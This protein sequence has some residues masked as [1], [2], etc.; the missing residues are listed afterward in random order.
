MHNLSRGGDEED[1]ALGS[2]TGSAAWCGE[3][4]PLDEEPVMFEFQLDIDEGELHAVCSNIKNAVPVI[5][6]DEESQLRPFSPSFELQEGDISEWQE[7]QSSDDQ[8]FDDRV[9]G[10]FD[11]SDR[12]RRSWEDGVRTDSDGNTSTSSSVS[13]QTPL[14]E[15][16][17]SPFDNVQDGSSVGGCKQTHV[18]PHTNSLTVDIPSS[19]E[20]NAV[21][22]AGQYET[23]PSSI[24]AA[25]GEPRLNFA[26][27]ES[28]HRGQRLHSSECSFTI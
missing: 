2:P 22:M 21:D 10:D 27:P 8:R 25:L 13:V 28:P 11:D 5:S 20:W 24:S 7:N 12:H 18:H 16:S 4:G 23:S 1:S 3:A 14:N 6:A 26:Y 9:A 19:P 15:T 17:C